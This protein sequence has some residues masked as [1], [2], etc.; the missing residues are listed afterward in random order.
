MRNIVE[1]F[2]FEWLKVEQNN[3]YKEFLASLFKEANCWSYSE[4]D[5]C[6]SCLV[7]TLLKFKYAYKNWS[8]LIKTPK[9][10]QKPLKNHY[11]TQLL[12]MTMTLLLI[13]TSHKYLKTIHMTFEI[14]LLIDIEYTSDTRNALAYT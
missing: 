1:V 12:T 10:I 8:V 6:L 2:W 13:Y 11:P 7:K 14:F 4:K 3:I 9:F 5:F